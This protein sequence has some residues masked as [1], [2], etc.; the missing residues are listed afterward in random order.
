MTKNLP[1]VNFINILG[2]IFLQEH[3]FGSFF[4]VHVTREKAAKTTFVQKIRM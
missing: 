2:T 1:G 3:C 4:Y